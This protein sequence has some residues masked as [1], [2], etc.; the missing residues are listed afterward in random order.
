MS[1]TLPEV[2]LPVI[3][4][5][6]SLIELVEAQLSK[7]V[8]AAAAEHAS[9]E[10]CLRERTMAMEREVHAIVLGRLDEPTEGLVA[11]MPRISIGGKRGA[12][13][14]G[15]QGATS[16]A[17]DGGRGKRVTDRVPG[18]RFF[19]RTNRRP[20]GPSRSPRRWTDDACNSRTADGFPRVGHTHDRIK[21]A[22]PNRNSVGL[23][24]ESGS[25]G[26]AGS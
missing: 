20:G 6:T 8:D 23:E 13:S 19:R 22:G 9:F 16:G 5:L 3:P 2:L 17:H 24:V 7:P 1:F 18:A 21:S 11:P 4:S 25:T 12:L 10:R 14:A 26:Q 15:G